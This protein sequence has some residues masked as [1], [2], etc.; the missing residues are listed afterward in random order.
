MKKS[1]LIE[2]FFKAIPTITLHHAPSE[3]LYD[4]MK[5]AIKAEILMLFG[6][7]DEKV[8][9]QPFGELQFPYHNM[10][11]INTTNLFEID[12]LIIFSF[13]WQN[14]VLYQ[15]VLDIGANVGLHS[16]L[17]GKCGFDVSSYEPDNTHF[18]ILQNNLSLN[19]MTNIKPYNMAV[20]DH[21]G[22][23]EFVRVLGNTTGS[24]LSG[25]KPNP[26]GDL[27]RYMVQIKDIRPMLKGI[28]FVKLDIEA[29][30][31]NVIPATTYEDWKNMDGMV[32]V[33]DESNATVLF[34]HFNKLGLNLFSQKINWGLA[35]SV[36]DIPFSH[37][38][39]SLFVTAK[40]KMPWGVHS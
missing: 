22:E 12:E 5:N 20:S 24:H 19:N 38:D 14:R 2:S 1:E 39:G 6:E 26:Y 11:N 32:S 40:D 18:K 23:A 31:K 33:H 4:F 13:Y 35:K 21:E 7:T 15:K 25:A 34:E 9:F 30:E 36:E 27:E 29:H 16:L 37:H 10:G 17:L 3:K 28:D 8:D